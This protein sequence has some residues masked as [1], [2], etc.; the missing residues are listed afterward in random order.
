MYTFHT[1][2]LL[3]NTL[4]RPRK[5]TMLSWQYIN[6]GKASQCFIRV[7]CLIARKYILQLQ[8]IFVIY[9]TR[10][11][12]L[13]SLFSRIA[14]QTTILSMLC[15][16]AS[17]TLWLSKVLDG[18]RTVFATFQLDRTADGLKKRNLRS[19]GRLT[20]AGVLS[21]GPYRF[22]TIWTL[23]FW[24]LVWSCCWWSYIRDG[25][26]RQVCLQAVHAHGDT[27]R[28]H[29]ARCGGNTSWFLNT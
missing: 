5:H 23:W 18:G 4:D 12:T 19:D 3:V 6:T 28:S 27:P 7:Y 14:G 21:L 29:A 15:T 25:P 1:V 13:S 9:G 11:W 26:V 22:Y 24:P 20:G 10:T 16:I 2:I 8:S 17:T